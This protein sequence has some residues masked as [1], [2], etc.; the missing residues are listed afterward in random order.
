MIPAVGAFRS[1][2]IEGARNLLRIAIQ[3]L[4]LVKAVNTIILAF[5]SCALSE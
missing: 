2:D 3:V 4:L 5:P 1:K